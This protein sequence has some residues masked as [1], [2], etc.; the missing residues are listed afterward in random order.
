MVLVPVLVPRWLLLQQQPRGILLTQP[1]QALLALVLVPVSPWL[2]RLLQQLQR[3]L[4]GKL[5]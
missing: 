1:L 5:R 2:Q 4:P 3:Q